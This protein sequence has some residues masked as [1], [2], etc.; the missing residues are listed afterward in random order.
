[1]RTATKPRATCSRNSITESL[2]EFGHWLPKTSIR[3]GAA[4]GK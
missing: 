3:H 4:H 2:S 1:M